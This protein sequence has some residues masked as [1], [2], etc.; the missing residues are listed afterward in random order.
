MLVVNRP[1]RRLQKTSKGYEM[2]VVAFVNY[3]NLAG[4]QTIT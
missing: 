2:W 1:A 3:T 4:C